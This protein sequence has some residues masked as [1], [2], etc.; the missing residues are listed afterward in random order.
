MIESWTIKRTKFEIFYILGE[1]GLPC[2]P[3]LNAENVYNDPHLAA[4]EMIVTLE[5]PVRG[6]FMMPG[7]PVKPSDSSAGPGI[8]PTLGQ[9]TYDVL[10]ELLNF[11]ADDLA[12]LRDGN[13]LNDLLLL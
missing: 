11:G 5:H 7:Y 6:P 2:G 4:R 10:R 3:T 9:H 13:F 12:E 1:A 8:T